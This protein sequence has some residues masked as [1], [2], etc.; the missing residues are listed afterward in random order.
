MQ[1]SGPGCE[2]SAAS[3]TP[4]STLIRPLVDL[5]KA[6][7]DDSKAFAD[8]AVRAFVLER[9]KPHSR[10]RA[11]TI[12]T[13][14]RAFLR[15]LVATGQC[16]A[17]RDYAV[18]RFA[19]WQLASVPRFLAANDIER[20]IAACEGKSRLRD[21]TIVLL[22]ARLGLRASEVANLKLTDI[23][24]RNGRLAITGKSRR[25]AWLPLTQEVGDAIIVYLEQARPRLPTPQLFF[26]APIRPLTRIAVKCIVRSNGGNQPVAAGADPSFGNGQSSGRNQ[27]ISWIIGSG[28]R[29]VVGFPGA[30]EGRRIRSTP[31]RFW[32]M[33]SS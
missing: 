28:G 33:S 10:G 11:K 4:H 14:T 7:G 26:T 32:Q 15:F 19:N 25:E 2:G 23:D 22:L 29:R 21:R 13:S 20:T 31:I 6:V 5:L 27:A 18:P 24:W 8:H 9:A 30:G 1:H 17:G 12:A 16:P 3:P